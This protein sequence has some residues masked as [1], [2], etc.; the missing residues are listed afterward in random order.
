VGQS[1]ERIRQR[2]QTRMEEDAKFRWTPPWEF[3]DQLLRLSVTCPRSLSPVGSVREVVG[4]M[5]AKQFTQHLR[6]SRNIVMHGGVLGTR[7]CG[8]KRD[9]YSRLG[10]SSRISTA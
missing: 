6:E 3:R 10:S 7:G 1:P 8:A 5:D 9:E 4:N 2:V